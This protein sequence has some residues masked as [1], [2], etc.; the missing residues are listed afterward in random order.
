MLLGYLTVYPNNQKSQQEHEVRQVRL[1]PYLY[2][3]KPV[4]YDNT[5]SYYHPYYQKC[6]AHYKPYLPYTASYIY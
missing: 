3:Y 4:Y 6:K 2:F 5:N 1:L